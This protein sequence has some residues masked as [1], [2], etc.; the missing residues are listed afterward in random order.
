MGYPFTVSP[1]V[2]CGWSYIARRSLIRA[3]QKTETI[4]SHT[5]ANLKS[6]RVSMEKFSHFGGS[7]SPGANTDSGPG[8]SLVFTEADRS[9]PSADS[10]EKAFDLCYTNYASRKSAAR[11][12]RKHRFA[13][14]KGKTQKSV[15]KT[16]LK[17]KIKGEI[18]WVS[19]L[20]NAKERT[21][22]PKS[23]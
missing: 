6:F 21:N 3:G 14:P 18:A 13:P 11:R 9:Y 7:F 12:A 19:P 23:R 15:K 1:A 20:K 17:S 4:I 5:A 10:F 2:F 16:R 8:A 22:V